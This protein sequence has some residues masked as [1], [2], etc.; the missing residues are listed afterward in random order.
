MTQLITTKW[1]FTQTEILM[2]QEGG[3]KNITNNDKE[4]IKDENI[5]AITI[6]ELA[7]KEKLILSDYIYSGLLKLGQ[8]YIHNNIKTLVIGKKAC[9][10]C[11]ILNTFRLSDNLE[12][13]IIDDYAFEYSYYQFYNYFLSNRS[14]L[15]KLKY[16]KLGKGIFNNTV[17]SNKIEKFILPENLETLVLDNYTFENCVDLTD[18]ILNDNLKNL[19][20]GNQTFIG[21]N[22]LSKINLPKNIKVITLLDDNSN[23]YSVNN[24]CINLIKNKNLKILDYKEKN[25]FMNIINF[26]MNLFC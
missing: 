1:D 9:Y 6:L 21:C 24:K 23:S 13:L 8:I 14:E 16:L 3:N 20:I 22:K 26:I 18:F 12:T 11:P 17:N 25:L 7:D 5:N 4:L 15:K 19:T 10:G 2:E